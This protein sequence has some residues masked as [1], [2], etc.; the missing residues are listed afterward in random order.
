MSRKSNRMGFRNRIARSTPA[1]DDETHDWRIFA[2]FVR[3]STDIART[4]GCE[5][6]MSVDPDSL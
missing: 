4:A 1:D 3:Q 2:D 6:R 5:D